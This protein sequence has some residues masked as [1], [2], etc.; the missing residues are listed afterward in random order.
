[1]PVPTI[2]PGERAAEIIRDR[3]AYW[4]KR[5]MAVK[6]TILPDG[7]FIGNVTPEAKLRRQKYAAVTALDD[8]P[9]LT[10]P[11]YL[12]EFSQGLQPMP[13]SPY[14]RNLMQTSSQFLSVQR[15]FRNLFR[16]EAAF[17]E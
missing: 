4:V 7:I 14:W 9:L 3:T 15:D 12:E 5:A 6:E 2:I 17:R 1:M 8:F 13:Q 11:K 10:N 16:S